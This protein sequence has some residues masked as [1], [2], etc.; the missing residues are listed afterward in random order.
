MKIIQNAVACVVGT[1]LVLGLTAGTAEAAAPSTLMSSFVPAQPSSVCGFTDH[2]LKQME[3][4]KISPLDVQMAVA[5]GANSAFLNRHGNWQY[6]SGGVIAVLNDSGC[7]V[8][9]FTR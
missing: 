2:A 9:V 7:V 4:R 3:E 6:E 8:T 5:L 1:L